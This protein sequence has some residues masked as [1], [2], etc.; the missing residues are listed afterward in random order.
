MSSVAEAELGALFLNA[1]SSVPMRK[2]L[3]EIGHNQTQTP[4]QTDK[5]T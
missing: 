4:I 5:K 3:K 1:K 2:T